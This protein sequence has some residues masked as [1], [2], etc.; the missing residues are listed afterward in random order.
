MNPDP[1]RDDAQ[2]PRWI[3]SPADLTGGA[4]YALNALQQAADTAK[5]AD[6]RVNLTIGGLLAGQGATFMGKPMVWD[7]HWP[8]GMPPGLTEE[9]LRDLGAS[10]VR[11]A[12]GDPTPGPVRPVAGAL[13]QALALIRSAV[14]LRQV[15][16]ER[17]RPVWPFASWREW[18]A[19][20]A[21]LLKQ[22]A[23]QADAAR[24]TAREGHGE[25]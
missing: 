9:G 12:G 18:D 2:Q 5:R 3:R 25:E 14:E 19:D 13:A 23:S 7:L 24:G 21:S 4:A 22:Q 15:D 17:Q 8:E 16:A 1:E 20:A 11:A 6:D 10:M